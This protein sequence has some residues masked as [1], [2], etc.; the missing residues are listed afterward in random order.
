MKEKWK[1]RAGMLCLFLTILS[2]TIAI[3]INFTPLYRFDIHYLN[4]LNQV[5]GMTE[6]Q[7]M[8]NYHSLMQYLNLPWVTKL[9]MP[10]FPSSSSGLLHFY[11]VKKLFL[12][13]YGILL[14]TLVPSFLFIRKMITRKR[15]WMLIRP[16]QMAFTIPIILGFIMSLSFNQFFVLFHELFFNNDAWLFDA[17]TDPIILALP[18][19]FFMHCFILAFI[20]LELFFIAGILSG[21]RQLKKG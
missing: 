16:F 2:L 13:D 5:D 8:N 3:A 9:V 20:L 17:S 6:K 18:A 14:I 11:E 12:L 15:L 21:K 10:D 7:L 4:I 19:D 1:F